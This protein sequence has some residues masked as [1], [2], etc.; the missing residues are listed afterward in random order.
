MNRRGQHHYVHVLRVPGYLCTPATVKHF[1]TFCRVIQCFLS[2]FAFFYTQSASKAVPPTRDHLIPPPYCTEL[3]SRVRTERQFGRLQD[4]AKLNQ[5]RL[6]S[7]E[8]V[9]VW[10]FT[11]ACMQPLPDKPLLIQGQHWEHNTS[12]CPK[13]NCIDTL[14]GRFVLQ[15]YWT[16]QSNTTSVC[17]MGHLVK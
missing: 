8:F 16:K 12:T 4:I 6:T 13:Q 11:A 15:Q 3:Q 2:F 7:H 9:S 17:L 10:S 1:N 14:R 5:T